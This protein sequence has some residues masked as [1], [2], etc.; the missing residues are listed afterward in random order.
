MLVHLFVVAKNFD[1]GGLA[2]LGGQGLGECLL[3]EPQHFQRIGIGANE[4]KGKGTAGLF[5]TDSQ[6]GFVWQINGKTHHL[7][8]ILVKVSHTGSD[9]IRHEFHKG[10]GFRSKGCSRITG[11]FPVQ[12]FEILLRLRDIHLGIR[13]SIFCATISVAFPTIPP[14]FLIRGNGFPRI[15]LRRSWGSVSIP[16]DFGLLT[17]KRWLRTRGVDG[18]D[19]TGR[20]TF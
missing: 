3:G 13:R 16:N 10:S 6:L 11:K 12:Y 19:R 4:A 9:G 14:A 17:M 15:D 2:R 18:P 8:V 7:A 20:K 1:T 5:E